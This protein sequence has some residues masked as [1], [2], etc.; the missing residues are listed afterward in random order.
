VRL[1][2][3][4]VLCRLGFRSLAAHLEPVAATFGAGA[5]AACVVDVGPGGTSIACVE[6]GV[7]A[8]EAGAARL[9]P[10][11]DAV[12]RTLVSLLRAH[13]AWPGALAPLSAAAMAAAAAAEGGPAAAAA[14]AEGGPAAGVEGGGAGGVYALDLLAQLRDDWCY[15]VQARQWG[16]LPGRP[17]GGQGW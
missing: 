15:C 3:D 14:A 6:E 5:S 2:A 7:L 8:P 11:G 4:L 10:G 16:H 9:A 12:A 17:C 13:G 1:L